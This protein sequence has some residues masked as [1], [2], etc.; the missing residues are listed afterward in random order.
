MMGWMF[1]MF[2]SDFRSAMSPNLYLLKKHN[3]MVARRRNLEGQG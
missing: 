2:V 1:T 3:P